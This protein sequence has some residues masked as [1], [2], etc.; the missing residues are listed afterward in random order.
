MEIDH[1]FPWLARYVVDFY[2]VAEMALQLLQQWQGI[3]VVAEAHGFAGLQGRQGAEYRRMAESLGYAAGIE[4]MDV[5]RKY[6][7]GGITG[8]NGFLVELRFESS[9]NDAAWQAPQ[10]PEA[11]I[12]PGQILAAKTC[13]NYR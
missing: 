9:R 3:V 6:G 13:L 1:D 2:V 11:Y 5:L 12:D 4:G 7:N 8:H 10:G